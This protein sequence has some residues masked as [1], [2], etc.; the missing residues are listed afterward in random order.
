MCSFQVPYTD[1]S[2]MLDYFNQS[3]MIFQP[4][5][6]SKLTYIFKNGMDETKKKQIKILLSNKYLLAKIKKLN[7]KKKF[8][9]QTHIPN[10]QGTTYHK[11]QNEFDDEVPVDEYILDKIPIN[12]P[13]LVRQNAT[14]QNI[15]QN[16]K[17]DIIHYDIYIPKFTETGS[18][19]VDHLMKNKNDNIIPSDFKYY[20]KYKFNDDKLKIIKSFENL[21]K[22]FEN[23]KYSIYEK[24]NLFNIEICRRNVIE[25]MLNHTNNLENCD[26]MYKC[27]NQ[28]SETRKNFI[29][30]H[31]S[32]L[33]EM[34]IKFHTEYIE[35]I[36]EKFD[37][38]YD[39][40]MKLL[41]S[42]QI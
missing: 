4:T 16:T 33:I 17:V 24:N 26:N 21:K 8:N 23:F 18:N 5:A 38:N 27:Y 6:E 37:E 22:K 1:E 41:V 13:K 25:A 40:L 39:K 35:N 2:S 28:M 9:Q 31:H 19:N 32:K 12:P 7:D 3:V 30:T 29:K 42:T 14:I 34:L 36:K 11:T 10:H 15:E 20:M